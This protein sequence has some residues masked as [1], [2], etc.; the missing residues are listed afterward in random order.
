MK[1]YFVKARNWVTR[2]LD[3]KFLTKKEIEIFT[4]YLLFN[5]PSEPRVD[6]AFRLWKERKANIRLA[7]EL[8]ESCYAV[9]TFTVSCRY[10]RSREID[11]ILSASDDIDKA[12]AAIPED[13]KDEL[14][15]VLHSYSKEVVILSFRRVGALMQKELD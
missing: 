13:Y 14:L 4:H 1:K 11:K 3:T 12:F 5:I 7:V 6:D 9:L 8:L 2:L 10:Y 15:N